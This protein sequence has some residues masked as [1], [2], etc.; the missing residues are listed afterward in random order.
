MNSPRR[1]PWESAGGWPCVPP[2]NA[3]CSPNTGFPKSRMMRRPCSPRH[4][5]SRTTVDWAARSISPRIWRAWRLPW[6]RPRIKLDFLPRPLLNWD[7]VLSLVHQLSKAMRTILPFLLFLIAPFL[8]PAQHPYPVLTEIATDRAGIFSQEQL[9]G[10]R[11][12]LGDFERETGHQ[13]VV[14]TLGDL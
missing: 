2:A 6:P 9:E 1:G 7:I 5:L 8:G 14:L 11:T 12:K 4:F 13:L 10:L 3:M